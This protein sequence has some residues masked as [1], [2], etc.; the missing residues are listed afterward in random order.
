MTLCI[1]VYPSRHL[2]TLLF[3]SA[4]DVSHMNI[5]SSDSRSCIQARNK[6]TGSTFDGVYSCMRQNKPGVAILENVTVSSSALLETISARASL[7]VTFNLH[8]HKT[9]KNC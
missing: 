2:S 7:A 4:E 1:V 3:C 6:K 8:I 9:A 5:Y